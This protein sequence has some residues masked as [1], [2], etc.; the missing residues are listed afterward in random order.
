M[1]DETSELGRLMEQFLSEAR[2]GKIPL[3]EDYA[4]RYPDLAVRI[5][6]LFPILMILEG[7]TP[8]QDQAP[9]PAPAPGPGAGPAFGPYLIEEEIGRNGTGVVC[10][11]VHQ[12]LERRV[13]LRILPASA[14]QDDYERFLRKAS[15]AAA[16]HHSNIVPVVD[17]GQVAGAPYL[18]SQHIEGRSLEQILR[19]MQP[20][21]GDKSAGVPARIEDYWRWVA[22]IGIQAAEGLA[23]AHARGVFHL[24]VRPSNLILDRTGVLW[25]ADFGLSR[26]CEHPDPS[27]DIRGLGA[28]LHEM[29][30]FRP[31]RVDPADSKT[32]SPTGRRW[33][34][35]GKSGAGAPHSKAPPAQHSGARA[36]IPNHIQQPGAWGTAP[37]DLAAVARKAMAGAPEDQYRNARDLAEDLGRC[38][39]GEPIGN[40]PAGP[41]RQ[42]AGWCRRNSRLTAALAASLAIILGASLIGNLLL[43]RQRG[44]SQARL[45]RGLFERAR[46]VRLLDRPGRRWEA[47]ELL[48]QAAAAGRGLKASGRQGAAGQYSY[49]AGPPS[50]ADI[51]SEAVAA[52]LL[53]DGRVGRELSADPPEAEFR[54]D[55]SLAISGWVTDHKRRG[56]RIFDFLSGR[57]QARLACSLEEI[58][59]NAVSRDGRLLA[60]FRSEA[61]DLLALPSGTVTARLNPPAA[62]ATAAGRPVEGPASYRQAAFSSG[63][64]YLAAV[65]DFPARG[66]EVVLWDLLGT[67]ASKSLA[68]A[69]GRGAVVFSDDGSRIAFT[70]GPQHVTILALPAMEKRAEIALPGDAGVERLAFDR[71]GE[72]LAIPCLQPSAGAGTILIWD[73][74]RNAEYRSLAA[75]F[76]PAALAF[77]PAGR[78]LAASGGDDLAVFDLDAGGPAPEPPSG[79]ETLRLRNADREISRLFWD[80]GG[81]GLI[82]GSAN[83]IKS[84]ELLLDSPERTAPLAA[85]SSLPQVDAAGSTEARAPGGHLMAV[86]LRD[87]TVQFKDPETGQEIFRW[88]N[89]GAGQIRF[90]PDGNS[91]RVV[92]SRKRVIRVL[93]LA[94][95]RRELTTLGIGW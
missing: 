46:A 34:R 65:A 66:C 43:F 8:P 77:D 61:V 29:L 22:G 37:K 27:S 45:A 33:R 83:G 6:A 81:A 13:A 57:D 16:L 62:A 30:T 52:L 31:A 36:P 40:R 48:R 72:L 21:G 11:A 32:A 74:A 55:S 2:S 93:D 15:A 85:D 68:A 54:A 35:L 26:Q 73:C 7:M 76:S 9:A 10:K 87:G 94:R 67:A 75:G 39:K 56:L 59:G 25:I 4:Q 82:T 69:P 17:A 71:K 80:S 95:L 20:D 92:D 28:V 19:L 60:V 1:P 64:R 41:V 58:A 49:P 42:A 3:I 84:W 12:V 70:S 90:A 23:Y 78:F 14:G 47:L 44:E 86:G 18:A 53:R 63:G 24:A 89:S 51:R 91:V 5:R 50:E 88:E 38:L 79:G